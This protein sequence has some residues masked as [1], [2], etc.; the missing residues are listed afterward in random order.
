MF[1][2]KR[3][4]LLFLIFTFNVPYQVHYVSSSVM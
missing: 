4:W 2:W 1:L 3:N